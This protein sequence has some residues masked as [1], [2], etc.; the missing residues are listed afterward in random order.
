MVK[1]E[2][3]TENLRNQ[4]E[5]I[6]SNTSQS[7]GDGIPWLLVLT[8]FLLVGKLAGWWAGM[9]W[10]WVFSPLWLPFACLLGIFVLVAC[11]ALV[12]GIFIFIMSLLNR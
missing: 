6:T 4:I 1:D 8:V 3:M 5:E 7:A 10:A 12:G 2:M 9:S 11:V